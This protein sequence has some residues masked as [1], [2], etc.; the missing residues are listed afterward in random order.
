MC[1]SRANAELRCWLSLHLPGQL[2]HAC[3]KIPIRGLLLLCST[4]VAGAAATG[5]LAL[6]WLPGR[7]SRPPLAQAL[8][9]RKRSRKLLGPLTAPMQKYA[10]DPQNS[11]F[12]CNL[13][14]FFCSLVPCVALL[15]H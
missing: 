6:S 14:L 11:M 9:I 1:P 4:N 13:V 5:L 10:T 8:A 2:W 15:C 7:T 12:F 3:A